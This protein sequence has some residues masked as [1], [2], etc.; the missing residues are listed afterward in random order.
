MYLYGYEVLRIFAGRTELKFVDGDGNETR[1]ITASVIAAGGGGH[2]AR[3]QPVSAL[4]LFVL[5]ARA[6]CLGVL[7]FRRLRK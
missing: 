7:G 3:E 2:S 1:P 4:P 6:G 5:A